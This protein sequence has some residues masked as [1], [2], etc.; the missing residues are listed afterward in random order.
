MQL[1]AISDLHL[2]YRANRRL[3]GNLPPHPDDWLIVAGDLAGGEERFCEALDLLAAR[4]A[5]VI[6]VPGNHE[7]W[8]DTAPHGVARY[9]RLVARCR[10]RGVLTPEDP[11]AVWPGPPGPHRVAPLFLLYDYTFRPDHVAVA[12][13]VAWAVESGVLCSDEQLLR[14]DPYPT[15]QAWCAA[16]CRQ[17]AA[18][19]ASERADLPTVLINHWPLRAEHAVLPRIPRFTPWC[20]TRAAHDWHRRFDA[21]VVVYGHLHIRRT[22][23][24]DGTRFEE[25]SLGYPRQY[26]PERPL[27]YYLRAVLPAA[28]D[29]RY[30]P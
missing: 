13:A 21:R 15:R 5:R 9:E 17:T 19:L 3:L 22:R 24:C 18:R 14:P 29:W 28:N 8:S 12:D 7:L 26:D 4:F 1:W 6:W 16:R 23:W 11:Y 2:S 30:V 20:G 25:V 10:E 27:E